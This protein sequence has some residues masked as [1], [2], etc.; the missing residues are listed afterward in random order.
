MKLKLESARNES[1]LDEKSVKHYFKI[2]NDDHSP[3]DF[4]YHIRSLLKAWKTENHQDYKWKDAVFGFAT[5]E[6][7]K[8]TGFKK[9]MGS[10]YFLL[11]KCFLAWIIKLLKDT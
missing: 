6:L 1:D 3:E 5:Q 8:I 11:S 7:A 4:G 10:S 2:Q 9:R